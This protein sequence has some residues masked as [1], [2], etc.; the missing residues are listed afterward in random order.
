[1]QKRVNLYF[2]LDNQ[3]DK[4]RWEYLNSWTNKKAAISKLIDMELSNNNPVR[5]FPVEVKEEI[6]SNLDSEEID[7]DGIEGF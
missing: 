1:M 6:E 4:A 2:N 3:E 7:M 5:L